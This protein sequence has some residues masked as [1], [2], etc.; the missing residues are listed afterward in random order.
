MS[1]GPK[2]PERRQFGRRESSNHGWI[3]IDGRPKLPCVISNISEGG[4]LLV[5]EVPTWLPFH[6]R[7]RSDMP[8]LDVECEVRHQR[9]SSIGVRFVREVQLAVDNRTRVSASDAVLERTRWTGKR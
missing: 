2:V 5:L 6:F 9:P 1:I 8:R 4:A 7:L 3:C